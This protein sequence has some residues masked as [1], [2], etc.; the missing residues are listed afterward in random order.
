[1]KYLLFGLAAL[2]GAT[3]AVMALAL[4]SPY[5][6][7]PGL[8]ALVAACAGVVQLD[9]RWGSIATA[10]LG[11]GSSV[12]LYQQKL[13]GEA[14]TA[15]CS[16]DSYIDCGKVNDSWASEA[17]GVPVT[18]FGA[19]YY[20]AIVMVGFLG[21]RGEQ[22]TGRFDQLN[23]VLGLVAVAYSAF[24]AWVSYTLGALCVVCLTMYAANVVLCAA[25]FVG[26]RRRGLGLGAGLGALLA[27]SEVRIAGVT[28]A[29][30]VA[31]SFN[32]G[33]DGRS[34]SEV[35]LAVDWSQL[36]RAS[37]AP[38]VSAADPIAGNPDGRYQIVEYADYGCGHC[39]R[40]KKDLDQLLEARSDVALVFKPFPLSGLCNTALPDNGVGQ[41]R[42]DAAAAALCAHRQGKFWPM[43]ELLFVNQGHFARDELRQMA[44][45]TGIDAAA[46]DACMADP[47][48]V[49]DLRASGQSGGDLGI[50][51][52]PSLFLRGLFD[53]GAWVRVEGGVPAIGRL[54]QAK[55]DG[56]ALPA[57]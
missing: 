45:Q 25:G 35:P 36:Y 18:A 56:V 47:T 20:L 10:L 6:L 33:D 12:Y 55:D 24:L 40:A 19:A 16:I 27:S 41:D 38:A 53:G 14:G 7:I 57:P 52:T 29:L 4:A 8:A 34:P 23:A 21:P 1:M 50:E 51:G 13:A 44:Q 48:I 39:A 32:R 30:A 22:D 42:C 28:F 26:L 46:W 2:L 15:A 43:S 31:V 37:A 11:L 49:D 5:A 3:W 17:F 54:L 9:L